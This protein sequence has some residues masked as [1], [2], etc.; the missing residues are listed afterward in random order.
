[1]TVVMSQDL[2]RSNE[3]NSDVMVYRILRRYPDPLRDANVAQNGSAFLR[4][5]G[6]LEWSSETSKTQTSS[7]DGSAGRRQGWPG[8]W[9]GVASVGRLCGVNCCNVKRQTKCANRRQDL[10]LD[11]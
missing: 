5:L 1:M 11:S 8:S 2:S 9:A 10:N 7:R 6:G 4:R 3:R